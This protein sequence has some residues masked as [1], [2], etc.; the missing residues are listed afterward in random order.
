MEWLLILAALAGLAALAVVLVESNITDTAGRLSGDA[1]LAAAVHAAGSVES[2]ARDASE[3]D[4]ELWA[5]WERHFTR[6]CSRIAILYGNLGAEVVNNN[7]RRATTGTSF[8]AVAAGY[9]AAGDEQPATATKAQA[10][11]EVS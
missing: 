4:F 2:E 10:Q 9:A 6:E 11:C 5:D 1:R 7:F 8:D 3:A